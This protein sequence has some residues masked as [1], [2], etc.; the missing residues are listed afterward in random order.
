VRLEFDNPG[1]NLRPGMLA[2]VRI[3]TRRQDH[4]V[5]VPAEAVIYSGERRLVFVALGDGHYEAREVVTGLIGDNRRT[6]VLAGLTK[7][8]LVVVSGQF[9]IDSE[10][11]LQEA[12][13]KLL[14]SRL[15]ARRPAAGSG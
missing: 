14:E 12:V 7:G 13:Q 5:T 15:E 1:L 11:Q 2:T 3:E 9:L 6:E 8:E 10:S 4:A